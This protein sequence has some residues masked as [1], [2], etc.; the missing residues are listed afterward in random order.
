[1]LA[2][3]PTP[4][5]NWPCAPQAVVEVEPGHGAVDASG[6]FNMLR[7]KLNAPLSR[8]LY[9]SQTYW[10]VK[11]SSS[12]LTTLAVQLENAIPAHVPVQKPGFIADSK[13]ACFGRL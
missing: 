8:S 11:L 4:E 9:I 12:L 5:V 10:P 13:N 3:M 6:V 1:M 2:F 7:A